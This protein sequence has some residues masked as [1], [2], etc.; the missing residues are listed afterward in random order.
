[1]NWDQVEGKWKQYKGAMKEKWG[2]LTDSDLDV[3]AGKRDQLV[4]R[5]QEAYGMTKEQAQ[6]EVE[7]YVRTMPAATDFDDPATA[8][9]KARRAG[10]P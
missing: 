1:M 8:A 7:D 5:I 2:K 9:S 6:R 3:I 4:G 10:Q